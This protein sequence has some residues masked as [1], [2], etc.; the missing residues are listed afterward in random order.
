[1]IAM[2]NRIANEKSLLDPHPSLTHDD[3][4][5]IDRPCLLKKQVLL[6]IVC[7]VSYNGSCTTLKLGLS[8]FITLLDG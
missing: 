5:G 1:M 8:M 3:Q 2:N 6:G 4:H 7:Q